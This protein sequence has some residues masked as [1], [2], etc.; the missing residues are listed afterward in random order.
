MAFS[1][2]MCDTVDDACQQTTPGS[3]RHFME[4]LGD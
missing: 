1:F 3:A 2:P 4:S